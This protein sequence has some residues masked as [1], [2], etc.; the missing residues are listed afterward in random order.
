[1]VNVMG[2]RT[3]VGVIGNVISFC[4]FM[5]PGITFFK[6]LKNKAV[7]GFKPD[8]YLATVLNCLFW[9]MYGTPL[10]HPGSILVSTI[11]GFGVFIELVFLFIFLFYANDNKQ[12]KY[13]GGILVLELVVFG[14]V[15]GLIL[16]LVPKISNRSRILG[17]ICIC[18]NICMYASPLTI[19][20]K[21]IQT[22]SVKYMPFWLSVTN[23]LNGACW[24]IY[25]LLRFDINL[26]IPN[27]LGFVCGLVQLAVY[28]WIWYLYR[29]TPGGDDEKQAK[30]EV[31]LPANTV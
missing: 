27:G 20:K 23:T 21:V 4:L 10:V 15:T 5:C 17:I 28:A 26:V 6:I 30:S 8:P 14:L 16:G 11:N 18:L 29:N 22:K 19:I 7:E 3:A 1:M 9:V 13:V 2:I 12:R 31:Q 25:G 24:T